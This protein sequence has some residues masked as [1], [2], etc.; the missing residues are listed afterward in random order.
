MNSYHITLPSNASKDVYTDN[1]PGSYRTVLPRPLLLTEGDWEVAL[2]SFQYYGQ[3]WGTI[4][5]DQRIVKLRHKLPITKTFVLTWN[6]LLHQ[7]YYFTFRDIHYYIPIGNYDREDLINTIFTVLK[8]AYKQ[9]EKLEI[10]LVTTSVEKKREIHFDM[11]SGA[12]AVE[13]TFLPSPNLQQLFNWS[14]VHISNMNTITLK[15]ILPVDNII[16]PTGTDCTTVYSNLLIFPSTLKQIKIKIDDSPTVLSLGNG[17][18]T[19]TWLS[20][21]IDINTRVKFNFGDDYIRE[22]P[23]DGKWRVWGP[24]TVWHAARYQA[25]IDLE[26][27]LALGLDRNSFPH[28]PNR[29][30]FGF[31]L[32]TATTITEVIIN[33]STYSNYSSLCDEVTQ[34]V[35]RYAGKEV[36]EVKFNMGT[37]T[38]RPPAEYIPTLV[39][40]NNITVK[41]VNDQWEMQL[42]AKLCEYLGMGAHMNKWFTAAETIKSPRLDGE[43]TLSNSI[44]G[45]FWVYADCIEEQVVGSTLKPLLRVMANSATVGAWYVE[46][47]DG[48]YLPVRGGRRIDTIKVWVC[49]GEDIQH[50]VFEEDILCILHFRKR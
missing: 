32:K 33:R 13:F 48:Y 39:P 40:D 23:A 1:V 30:D 25:S 16:S 4:P 20:E 37:R 36:V 43:L 35:N 29:R 14:D 10:T 28:S 2:V 42:S 22:R 38:I 45:A 7:T 34:V 44:I 19:A 26:T 18:W 47:L 49:G 46:I 3:K 41:M 9:F 31:D 17:V 6:V 50:L 24:C 27:S 5:K 12:N 8:D 11:L 15:S 21:Y